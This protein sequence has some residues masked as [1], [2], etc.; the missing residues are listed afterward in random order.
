MYTLTY[1]FGFTYLTIDNKQDTGEKSI[2]TGQIRKAIR[3]IYMYENNHL[4][5]VYN[6]HDI[7]MRNIKTIP[8]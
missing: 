3:I 5:W 1:F 6:Y 7:C 8:I 4:S 2:T